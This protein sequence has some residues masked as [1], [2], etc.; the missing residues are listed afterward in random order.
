MVTITYA[1]KDNKVLDWQMQLDS[2]VM[3]YKLEEDITLTEPVLFDNQEIITGYEAIDSY[4][5]ELME[6]KKAWFAC[7]CG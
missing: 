3:A 6:F 1:N 5:S 7:S 2:L 4:V